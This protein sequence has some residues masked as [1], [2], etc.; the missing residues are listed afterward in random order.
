MTGVFIIRR[1]SVLF[2]RALQRMLMLP[3][4]IHNLS[5]LGL[6]DFVSINSAN[7][8]ATTVDMQHDPRR[9][10]AILVEEA[11]EDVDDKLHRRVVV[12][13][14]QDLVHS[15][16]FRLRLSLDDDACT[17]SFLVAVLSVTAHSRPAQ[18]TVHAAIYDMGFGPPEET[19][20]PGTR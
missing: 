17:R 9:L 5:H 1:R 18:A 8:H 12:V 11:L 7:P 3:C 2:Q 4:K 16:L 15:R 10:L 13:Q 14:H 19:T 20:F 6:G